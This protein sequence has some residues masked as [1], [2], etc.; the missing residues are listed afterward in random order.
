[1]KRDPNRKRKQPAGDAPSRRPLYLLEF[2]VGP[3]GEEVRIRGWCEFLTHRALT[4]VLDE[5]QRQLRSGP[6]GAGRDWTNVDFTYNPTSRSG[7]I[8][9]PLGRMVGRFRIVREERIG[10]EA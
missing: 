8:E 7:R 9:A 3:H 10:G 5:W 6:V 2:E 1:M 4:S